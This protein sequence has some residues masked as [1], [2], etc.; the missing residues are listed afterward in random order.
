M[1]ILLSNILYAFSDSEQQL[2]TDSDLLAQNP[3]KQEIRTINN[4]LP[5]IIELVGGN[6]RQTDEYCYQ[7][8]FLLKTKGYL[9]GCGKY[10]YTEGKHM[11]NIKEVDIANM[12]NISTKE[13]DQL[14]SSSFNFDKDTDSI[15]LE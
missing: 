11:E 15:S 5:K 12:N 14:S 13:N 7:R 9:C 10:I 3:I 8:E 1:P 2:I 6:I 4:L